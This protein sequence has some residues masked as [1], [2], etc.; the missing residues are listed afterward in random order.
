MTKAELIKRFEENRDRAS[1]LCAASQGVTAAAHREEANIWMGATYLASQL[2]EPKSEEPPAKKARRIHLFWEDGLWFT[3]IWEESS[4][5]EWE[6]VW[7]GCASG[8]GA[9]SSA[10]FCAKQALNEMP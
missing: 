2:D 3:E 9:M 6:K 5:G 7:S 8:F 10:A 4:P 1:R